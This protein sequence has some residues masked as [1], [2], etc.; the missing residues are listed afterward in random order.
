MIYTVVAWLPII[1]LLETGHLN[2]KE[3]LLKMAILEADCNFFQ[4]QAI[5]NFDHDLILLIGW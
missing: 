2:Y 1:D 4:K 3:I 5:L